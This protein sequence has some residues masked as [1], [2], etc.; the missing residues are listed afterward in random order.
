MSDTTTG[1]S[2]VRME[3]VPGAGE[4]LHLEGTA[5]L[6]AASPDAMVLVPAG[7]LVAFGEVMDRAKAVV[8]D[9][10]AKLRRVR[11]LAESWTEADGWGELTREMRD[12]ANCGREILAIIDG[13]GSGT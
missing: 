1:A 12:E 11:E 4:T 7:E 8:A 13:D 6:M 9:R 3:P 5:V 2:P 10:E